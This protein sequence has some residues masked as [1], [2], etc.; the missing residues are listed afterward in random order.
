MDCRPN[1]NKFSRINKRFEDLCAWYTMVTTFIVLQNIIVSLNYYMLFD[2][3][4]LRNVKV[5][6]DWGNNMI[7]IQGN[8]I[9]QTIA[10]IKHLVINLK[11]LEA[12]L[13]FD[14][15]NAWHYK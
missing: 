13:C 9:V 1:N 11:R 4:W 10:V 7:M 12:L 2:R 6:H 8:V 15:Q 5:A 14:Y 3:P